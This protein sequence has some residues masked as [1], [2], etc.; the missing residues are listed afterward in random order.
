[1]EMKNLYGEGH[2]IAKASPQTYKCSYEYGVPNRYSD[3][4]TTTTL[5][6][7]DL[8]FELNNRTLSGSTTFSMDVRRNGWPIAT[9][10]E[11]AEWTGKRQD[12]REDC[13]T[14]QD[15]VNL[16]RSRVEADQGKIRGLNTGVGSRRTNLPEAAGL[17]RRGATA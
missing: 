11:E 13:A 7:G 17:V 12:D 3:G 9:Y 10:S 2:D 16:P 1:M 6:K 8:T 4:S 5:Y 15:T 14:A